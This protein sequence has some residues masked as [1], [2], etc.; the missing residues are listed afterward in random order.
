MKTQEF[1]REIPELLRSQLPLALQDFHTLGPMG[2][3]I[4]FHYGDSHIHYEV[5][6][7]R[8]TR[9]VEVGLHFESDPA[10][11]SVYLENMSQH[12]TDLYPLLGPGVEPEQWTQSWT[13][14]HETMPLETLKEDF[15]LEVTAHLSRL[16]RVCLLYTSPSPRD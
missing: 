9:Q 1:L 7:Q 5:W 10:T 8:R 4:K 12:F 3:L 2:S 14:I 13:R 16:I 15:L 11:N 6:I